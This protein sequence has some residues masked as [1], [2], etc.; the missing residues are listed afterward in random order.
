MLK[1]L[2]SALGG[3]GGGIA[4]TD[5]VIDGHRVSIGEKIAEGGYGSIYRAKDNYGKEYAVKALIA[6]DQERLNS[7]V[8][9]FEFQKEVCDHTN[10]VKVYGMNVDRT[11]NQ[12]TIL[13]EF[14]NGE[15]VRE[16]NDNFSQGFP[17]RK[18]V[19]IFAAVTQ[20]VEYIHSKKPPIIHR[21]L[22]VE[23][24]LSNFNIYKLCDFGS[25]TRRVYDC[26]SNDERNIAADDIQ[27]NTTATYRS[28]EMCD[29]YRRQRIDFKSDIWALGC[30]LFKL[31]TFK[32]AFPEGTNL[33]ILN[34]R[35]QWPSDRQV[36]E[37][38]KSLVSLCFETDPSKRP[39]ARMIMQELYNRFPEQVD[40]KYAV[41]TNQ[42]EKK[43]PDGFEYEQPEEIHMPIPKDPKPK[44]VSKSNQ[45]A[46][47]SPSFIPPKLPKEE[48]LIDVDTVPNQISQPER[49]SEPKHNID[50]SLV[51]TDRDQICKL[52][53][54]M[55]ELE[56]SS[57]L[58]SIRYQYPDDYISFY[59]YLIHRSG[60]KAPIVLSFI[61]EISSPKVNELLS[62]KK[63]FSNEYPE[64]EGNY[65]LNSFSKERK[66]N[67]PPMGTKPVCADAVKN[68]LSIILASV[69]ALR[70][71]PIKEISEEAFFAY[72]ATAYLIAKLKI[73]QVNIG[74]IQNSAL[75]LINNHHSK[76][77]AIFDSLPEKMPFPDQPFNFDNEDF[78]K[79]IRLP[80]PKAL[81]NE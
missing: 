76:L 46:F 29:L 15:C 62:I 56:L 65:S 21:D 17:T 52:I 61:P 38:F 41:S 27:R 2:S 66:D 25:A 12:A 48:I 78:L 5:M 70:E 50:L 58:L 35:Y 60:R 37:R 18:I 72:Q 79:R 1:F 36:D 13:M 32:D 51:Q 75:P 74:Y 10:V 39:N 8:Q 22:K 67:P 6:P 64:Y 7:I 69:A 47:V 11:T 30:I 43:E 45:P 9:E 24:I 63:F 4:N 44:P 34:C 81:I 59:F 71:K 33:Q 54:Q 26:T 73:F 23:N 28:P 40:S 20:A 3:S 57:I 49:F 16:M 14:C 55:S 19:E 68:L 77:K 80:S 31:C 42:T 53:L